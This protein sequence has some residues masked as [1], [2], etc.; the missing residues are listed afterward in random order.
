[1]TGKLV[2]EILPLIP[3]P[4]SNLHQQ[5]ADHAAPQHQYNAKDDRPPE[6]AVAGQP[7]RNIHL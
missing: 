4:P 2:R 6:K 1:M 7:R 5:L 3:L